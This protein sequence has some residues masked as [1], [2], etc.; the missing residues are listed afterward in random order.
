[1]LANTTK[2]V[3][4]TSTQPPQIL[5]VDDEADI[6]YALS[7]ILHLEGYDAN[8]AASGAEALEMLSNKNYDLM[9]L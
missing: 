8:R 1:M 5:V 2:T 7:R 6:R 3:N 9:I 4:T